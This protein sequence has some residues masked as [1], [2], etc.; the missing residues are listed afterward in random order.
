[1]QRRMKLFYITGLFFIIANGL[2]TE[3]VG[4]DTTTGQITVTGR[5]GEDTSTEKS[6]TINGSHGNE[7]K[8]HTLVA[9][10]SEL[11]QG[12]LPKT[13]ALSGQ[14]FLWLG[15]LLVTAWLVI[16]TRKNHRSGNKRPKKNSY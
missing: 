5:I 1:M 12:K 10:I 9:D 16:S 2:L 15:Y 6:V 13:N 14:R 4:A 7:D 3:V 11:K 8:K